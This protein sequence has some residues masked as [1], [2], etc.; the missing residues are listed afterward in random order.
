[1]F[2]LRNNPPKQYDS[3]L[4]KI[5]DAMMAELLGIGYEVQG[6][7]VTI[8]P[9]NIIKDARRDDSV[10]MVYSFR[11]GAKLSAMPMRDKN[12]GFTIFGYAADGSDTLAAIEE[13]KML[14]AI[15]KARQHL[16]KMDKNGIRPTKLLVQF[17]PIPKGR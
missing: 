4:V 12:G 3:V 10:A 16:K 9:G 8:H 11:G 2:T 7:A 6:R 15:R 13:I 5:S 14:L 1:M 17:A